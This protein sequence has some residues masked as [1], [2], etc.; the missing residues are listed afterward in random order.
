MV[1]GSCLMS[2]E[3]AGERLGGLGPV[4][5]RNHEQDDAGH[6]CEENEQAIVRHPA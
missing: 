5:D 2:G 3:E 6:H 4:G 1:I